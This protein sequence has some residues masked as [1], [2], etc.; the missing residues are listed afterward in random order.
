[1]IIDRSLLFLQ[2]ALPP[3][4][5]YSLS[6]HDALPISR[7][8]QPLKKNKSMKTIKYCILFLLGGIVA[9]S[10]NKDFLD[11]TPT[12]RLSDA[13]ILSDSVLFEDFVVKR[14]MGARLLIKDAVVYHT[15]I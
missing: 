1:S 11:V 12:D 10:C 8:H 9:V 4:N 7:Y 2:N 15:G 3:N 13:A 14:T 6:L 5:L